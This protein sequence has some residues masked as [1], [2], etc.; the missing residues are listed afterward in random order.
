MG[1]HVL[2]FVRPSKDRAAGIDYEEIQ[3]GNEKPAY[4]IVLKGVRGVS[5]ATLAYHL[6]DSPA[7]EKLDGAPIVAIPAG[8]EFEVW[9][10]E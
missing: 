8:A 10:V 4:I 5:T 3:L 7:A 6:S 9:E 2:R 1:K